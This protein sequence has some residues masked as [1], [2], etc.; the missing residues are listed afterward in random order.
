MPVHDS[1]QPVYLTADTW[2]ATCMNITNST[3]NQYSMYYSSTYV[4]RFD[5]YNAI[6][7]QGQREG[8][9]LIV[10]L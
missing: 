8:K 1:S 5:L 4:D 9:S 10:A 3:S 2:S 6:P 7:F